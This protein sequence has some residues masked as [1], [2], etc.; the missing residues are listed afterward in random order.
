[1]MKR[2]VLLGIL[3]TLGVMLMTGVAFGDSDNQLVTLTIP[4][5][6][7]VTA[8]ANDTITVTAAAVNDTEIEG[9]LQTLTGHANAGYKVTVQATA[10]TG[11]YFTV[12]AA[13][14]TN[15]LI[16]GGLI[17]IYTAV[18]GTAGPANTLA[19]SGT[20]P[21]GGDISISDIQYK[22]TGL[23]WDQDPANPTITLTYTVVADT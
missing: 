18:A 10:Q 17:G 23:D 4:E 16:K 1:M 15:F 11:S 3:G 12:T 21:S 19:T 6:F 7:E 8:P 13:T 20:K 9:S 2:T 22:V 14:V 5:L